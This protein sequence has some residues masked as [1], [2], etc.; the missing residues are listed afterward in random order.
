MEQKRFVMCRTHSA[1]VFAGYL[2]YRKEKEAVLTDA[3]RIWYWAG[4]SSL[5]ELATRGTSKPLECK[6]PCPV[7]RIELTDV[8]EVIDITDKAKLSI[9]SVPE[10]TSH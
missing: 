5:S 3:I 7:S 1:G 6:F 2:E 10:W 8:I 4:A 9:Q